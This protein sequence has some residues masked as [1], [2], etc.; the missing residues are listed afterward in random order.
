MVRDKRNSGSGDVD[1]MDPS[2]QNAP[3]SLAI[4]DLLRRLTDKFQDM[5]Q[6]TTDLDWTAFKA[7]ASAGAAEGITRLICTYADG[8]SPST[9]YYLVRGHCGPGMPSRPFLMAEPY[10]L[11]LVKVEACRDGTAHPHALLAGG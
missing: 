6:E 9:E 1:F 2:L 7:L 5:P 4:L 8:D 11:A 10:E 3:A